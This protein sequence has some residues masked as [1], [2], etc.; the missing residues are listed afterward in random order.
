MYKRFQRYCCLRGKTYVCEDAVGN[1]QG[2]TNGDTDGDHEVGLTCL[3]QIAGHCPSGRVGVVRLHGCAT[4]GSV[5]VAVGQDV[6]VLSDDRHHDDV[7]NKAAE[8]GTPALGQEHD[9]RGDLE[10]LAHLQVVRQVDGVADDVVGPSSEVHVSDRALGHHQTRK[11]HG[12]VVGSNAV[13]ISGVDDCAL[14][15][16]SVSII[17]PRNDDNLRREQ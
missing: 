15:L 4:P 7:G 11:H 2:G 10:V 16:Q 17:H 8:D 1:D 5:A 13:T 9:T 14:L 3:I 12:Q 6:G